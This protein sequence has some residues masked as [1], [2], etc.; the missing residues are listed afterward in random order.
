MPYAALTWVIFGLAVDRLL[1]SD[2][3]EPWPV[4]IQAY[5]MALVFL[6]AA[7]FAGVERGTRRVG[8][9]GRWLIHGL[10]LMTLVAL[11][12]GVLL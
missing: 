9:G 12:L 5:A 3:L 2:S 6:P 1:P 4:A 10:V 11:Y 7:A 8:A